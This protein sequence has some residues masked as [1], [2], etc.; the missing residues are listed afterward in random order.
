MRHVLRLWFYLSPGLYALSQLED[1]MKN[2]SLIGVAVQ[3]NPW[4]WIFESYRNVNLYNPHYD[5]HV[6]LLG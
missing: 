4:T 6:E 5:R 1:Q 2:N 3:L